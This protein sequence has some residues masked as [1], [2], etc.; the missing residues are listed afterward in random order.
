LTGPVEVRVK[1]G[2]RLVARIASVDLVA[3]PPPSDVTALLLGDD[4]QQ[5]IFAAL[6]ANGDLWVPAAF[7]GKS[8]P[9][10][11]CP[12][13]LMMPM[14]IE[15]GA[16]GIPGL[17]M[18]RG[19]LDHIRRASLYFGDVTIDGNSFYGA[20]SPQRIPMVH[21]GGTRGV[22][23]CQM[24]DSLDLVLRVKGKRS[25]VRAR[26]S[27]MASIARDAAP[28][29]LQLRAARPMP[30]KANAPWLPDTFG[31][32]CEPT[33]LIDLGLRGGSPR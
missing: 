31:G 29:P 4:P 7:H 15:V 21:I 6:G 19:P 10:P 17:T 1:R 18:R 9:M 14:S 3:L 13:E 22:S 24:N 12:G 16:A 33:P 25:W 32:S 11:G 8:M 30:A 5:V 23:I 27:P 28:I 20:L 2:D 26:P